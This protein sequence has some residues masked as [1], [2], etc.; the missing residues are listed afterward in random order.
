MAVDS[1][2][3]AAVGQTLAGDASF[4]TAVAANIDAAITG[5]IEDRLTQAG[6]SMEAV[7]SS[8]QDRM[9]ILEQ[10]LTK[11]Q[12][13]AVDV[14][15]RLEKGGAGLDERHKRV[16]DAINTLNGKIDATK[17]LMDQM[18]QAMSRD[19]DN[20]RD[21]LNRTRQAL[22]ND[23]EKTKGD[24]RKFAMEVRVTAASS[25]GTPAATSSAKNTSLV[26]LKE[27]TVDKIPENICRADFDNWVEELYVHVDRVDGWAGMSNLLKE[28]R[29]QQVDLTDETMLKIVDRVHNADNDFDMSNFNFRA[30]DKD[31]YAYLLRKLNRKLKALVA[32]VRSGFEIFRRIMREEDPVT[33]ST[34]YSLRFAF[35]Q[36]VF[37]KC[38]NL[39]GTRKLIQAMEKKIS[40][41]REKT[42]KEMDE[43]LKALVIHGAMDAETGREVRRNRVEHTYAKIKGFI[44]ELYQEEQNRE[45]SMVSDTKKTKNDHKTD[46]MDVSHLAGAG[47]P[48][49]EANDED[50]QPEEWG[51]NHLDAVGKGKGKGKGAN[52]PMWRHWTPSAR[53]PY[54]RGQ[55]GAAPVL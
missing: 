43:V 40:E 9:G 34:E 46:A 12:D 33:E 31:L 21:D 27:T 23:F 13:T 37:Q 2:A 25:S 16:E 29:M 38:T 42:G 5:K 48:N 28:V 22:T 24:L 52:I 6:K 19:L 8:V 17:G 54:P 10:N 49:A 51:E 41:Y 15:Q 45:Y 18:K 35:Q 44:E 50:Q 53:M 47:V 14:L 30:R 1:A 7:F 36:M 20:A 4:V 11:T 39:E 32:G 55:H 26:T 3:V